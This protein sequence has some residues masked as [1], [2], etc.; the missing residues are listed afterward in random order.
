MN[1]KLE[2][3]HKLLPDNTS[4]KIIEGNVR[5]CFTKTFDYADEVKGIPDAPSD[6][7]QYARKNGAWEDISA[8]ATPTIA[9]VLRAGNQLSGHQFVGEL[10]LQETKLT[11]TGNFSVGGRA[12]LY[13]STNSADGSQVVMSIAPG[14]TF[15]KFGG[16]YKDNGTYK[17]T[18]LSVEKGKI[19][20]TGGTLEGTTYIAPTKDEEYV[21]KKYVDTKLV[22]SGGAEAR[23]P[24]INIKGC[25]F[26]GNKYVR[27]EFEVSGYPEF[28]NNYEDT[29]AESFLQLSIDTAEFHL[30]N[31][32]EIMLTNYG[33][34]NDH[35]GVFIEV[36]LPA[37]VT[38]ALEN[39]HHSS[40]FNF[41]CYLKLKHG[42]GYIQETFFYKN[43]SK[44][45]Q[46]GYVDITFKAGKNP[47]T[48]FNSTTETG[49]LNLSK[50]IDVIPINKQLGFLNNNIQVPFGTSYD[51]SQTFLN[52]GRLV[53]N[54]AI[55]QVT[56]WE[57]DLAVED[58]SSAISPTSPWCIVAEK[59]LEGG[60]FEVV[61]YGVITD[62]WTGGQTK[63]N[64][65]AVVRTITTSDM[66][67]GARKGLRFRVQPTKFMEGSQQQVKIAVN[68][69][70]RI[71]YS[72]S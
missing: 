61:G 4:G 10:K 70:R 2:E 6:N 7:K 66:L 5:E 23:K 16:S 21:Q 69:V 29:L 59:E 24:K 64:S 1:K 32:R 39:Y 53:P 48:D 45:N 43:S 62:N 41:A 8:K 18:I 68:K 26:A 22:S 51:F 14:A 13:S 42:T 34:G 38:T 55:S 49:V 35:A 15:F 37:S 56:D 12:M 20:V 36:E 58:G 67:F 17:D 44:Y 47:A 54:T 46:S 63:R 27:L 9:D 31:Q 19:K 60:T 72:I 28:I 71:S 57:F 33:A 30:D 25:S 52:N 11:Y 40:P 3:I 65:R 50:D